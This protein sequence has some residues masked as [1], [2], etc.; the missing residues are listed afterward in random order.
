MIFLLKL[1]SPTPLE[2]NMNLT[3]LDGTLLSNATLYRQL[4]GNLFYLTVTRADIVYTVHLVSQFIYAPHFTHYATILRILCYL[5]GT[6][7]KLQTY[8]DA[9]RAGDPTDR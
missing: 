9:D 8:Y 5:K 2:T 6:S 4:V 7:L 1:V 3:P